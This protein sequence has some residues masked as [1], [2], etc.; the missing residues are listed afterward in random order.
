MRDSS[1]SASIQSIVAAEVGRLDLA[2]D[3]FRE[4]AL[5]DLRDLSGNTADG[6]HLASL[7]GAWLTAVASFGSLPDHGE[8]LAFAPSL[9]PPLTRLSFRLMYRSR[10]IRVEVVPG[11]ARYELMAGEPLE[12]LHHG[13]PVTLLPETPVTL[14]WQ[15]PVSPHGRVAP[16]A[17]REAFLR[18]VGADE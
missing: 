5:V 11:R 18:G 3:Y 15:V 9:P 1:L 4:I 13:E 12:V 2:H 7:A 16:P 17:G 10:R 8:S 14:A 6:I